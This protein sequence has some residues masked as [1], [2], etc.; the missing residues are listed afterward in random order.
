MK[1]GIY[2]NLNRPNTIDVLKD[3]LNSNDKDIQ[4]VVS[5]HIKTQLTY[6]K[7]DFGDI[8]KTDVVITLGGDGTL[9]KAAR[10][11]APNGIPILGVNLGHLGFLTEVKKQDIQI[12]L[13]KLKEKK[14]SIEERMMLEAKII[15]NGV[16]HEKFVALNDIVLT[17]K[18]LSRMI[19][20]SV[21]VNELLLDNYFADG[22]IVSTPT[23]STAYSLSAGGPVLDPLMKIMIITPICPHSLHSRSI[24]ISEDKKVTLEPDSRYDNE[25]IMTI[26]G[27][28]SIDVGKD[29]KVEISNANIVTKLIKINNYN[30]YELLRRKLSER[31][32]N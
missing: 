32:I 11:C 22:I 4:I 17:R 7:C 27:Q 28:N 5:D 1:I 21:K 20:V 25:T 18:F 30:F 12:V 29:T 31:R 23:G 2:P 19:G 6:L 16:V 15:E 10:Q 14:Y 3:I 8:L 13:Q 26:D 24:A 9:I